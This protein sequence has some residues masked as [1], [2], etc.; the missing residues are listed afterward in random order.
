[1]QKNL[2]FILLA[3]AFTAMVCSEA[4]ETIQGRI[5]EVS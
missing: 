4:V 3:S 5:P 1:M 2:V